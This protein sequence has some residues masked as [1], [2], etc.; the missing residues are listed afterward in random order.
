MNT[1]PIP[2][3]IADEVKIAVAETLSLSAEDQVQEAMQK[4]LYDVPG[5]RP[6]LIY[7]GGEVVGVSGAGKLR[8]EVLPRTWRGPLGKWLSR[9]P[10]AP[11]VT[12]G[13][14]VADL[15]FL[16]QDLR[17]VEWLLVVDEGTG[18][19]VGVLARQVVLRT[20]PPLDQTAKIFRAVELRLWD[21]AQVK[22]VYY[23]CAVE[24]RIFGPD[25]VKHEGGQVRDRQGHVVEVR[26]PGRDG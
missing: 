10:P 24:G 1:N 14:R 17:E 8:G 15:L 11:E 12:A 18:K 3:T 4:G 26:T 6:V 23:Y 16:V 21:G 20:R 5:A 19:L 13:T 2:E 9:L 22:N 7:D 25:A